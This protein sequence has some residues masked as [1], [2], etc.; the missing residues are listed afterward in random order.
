MLRAQRQSLRTVRSPIAGVVTELHKQVGEFVAPND[1]DVL[2][3]VELDPLLARFS[4]PLSEASSLREGQPVRIEFSLSKLIAEGVVDHVAVVT[5]AESQTVQVT[6]SIGVASFPEHG[7]DQDAIF[8]AADDA[9][10]SAKRQGKNRVITADVAER[11]P[12]EAALV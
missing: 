2:A 10:Y 3:L 8:K 11:R 1:P 5:D 6:V 12:A 9:M 7:S 4:I